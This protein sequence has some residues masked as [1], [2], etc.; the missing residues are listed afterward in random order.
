MAAGL[1]GKKPAWI[2]AAVDVEDLELGLKIAQMA[3]GAGAEWIEVGTPLLFRYGYE[4]IAQLKKAAGNAGIVADYKFPYA[5]FFVPQA[6]AAGA[7]Y[8]T[9]EDC[10]NDEM[11]HQ[12]LEIGQDHQVGIIMTLLSNHPADIPERALRLQELGVEY[13]F[14]RREVSYKGVLYHC[15]QD[16]RPLI[17]GRI[18]VTDDEYASALKA[19]DDGADWIIFG[20]ALKKADSDLCRHWIDGIH[21]ER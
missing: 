2:Q 3:S 21:T 5:Q 1:E 4:A 16:L 7:D 18:G 13:F 8:V 6:A 10:Y 19:V 9:V 17:H 12:A 14:I 11:V 15:L 20:T